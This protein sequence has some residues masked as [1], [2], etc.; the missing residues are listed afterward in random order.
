MV[1]DVTFESLC[2]ATH[3]YGA[4]VARMEDYLL[5]RDPDTPIG[6]RAY[7][8]LIHG[9]VATARRLTWATH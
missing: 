4:M 5:S 9:T 1:F 7:R 3:T 2:P 6:D 8:I